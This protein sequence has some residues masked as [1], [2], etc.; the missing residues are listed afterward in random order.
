MGAPEKGESTRG[1]ESTSP[2][3]VGG[4][5]IEQWIKDMSDHDPSVR[6]TAIQ[7]VLQFGPAARKAVPALITETQD[8][9]A[10]IRTNAAVALGQIG[11]DEKDL[12]RGVAALVRLLSD[13]QA[14]VRYQATM[15]LG[16]IGTDASESTSYLATYTIKDLSSWPI[17]KAAAFALGSVAGKEKD[18]P[19]ARAINGLVYALSNDPSAQVKL[20]ALMS[21]VLL[22]PPK[23]DSTKE[24]AE[25]VL[26][27]LTRDKSHV[28]AIWAHVGLMRMNKVTE[29]GVLA[30][31]KLLSSPDQM[32]RM[33]AVRALVTL[34]TDAKPAVPMLLKALQEKDP[35]T[36][37][38]AAMALAAIADSKTAVP[39]LQET[40]KDK[41]PNV[42]LAAVQSLG[43]LGPLAKGAVADLITVVEKEREPFLVGAAVWALGEIGTAARAAIPALEKVVKEED[44]PLRKAATEAIDKI[45]GKKP[46]APK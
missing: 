4:K 14:I 7:T 5:T 40:L 35:T 21:I 44:E 2:K 41:E 37:H 19:D 26:R 12:K 30:I 27:R 46:K 11:F 8:R 9:D 18:D 29:S 16:R 22:G 45:Q 43:G 31:A 36:R 3:E 28:L 38:V 23:S 42:R 1:K 39:A 24:A 33:H 25:Q 15:A 20:E 6:E 13:S 17:R 32:T 10:S 34:G